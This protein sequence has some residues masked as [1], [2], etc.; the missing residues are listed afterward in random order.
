MPEGRT[1]VDARGYSPTQVREGLATPIGAKAM[2]EAG[3][4]PEANKA[5]RLQRRGR[6]L[7][8]CGYKGGGPD[9]DPERRDTP[10]RRGAIP[11]YK[12]GVLGYRFRVDIVILVG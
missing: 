2:P 11:P 10:G 6:R 9:N 4:S 12:T 7:K 3:N 1:A 8:P 5:V